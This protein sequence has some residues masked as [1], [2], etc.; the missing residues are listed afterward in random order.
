MSNVG[1][2]RE[3]TSLGEEFG[4]SLC[5]AIEAIVEFQEAGVIV[6]SPVIVVVCEFS[7]SEGLHFVP[8]FRSC[9]LVVGHQG[10]GGGEG[11]AEQET[12]DC[13]H[14]VQIIMDTVLNFRT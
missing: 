7:L 3:G 9:L 8:M 6:E 11:Q 10:G 14:F 4:S 12:N 13:F 2:V 5:V 1:F